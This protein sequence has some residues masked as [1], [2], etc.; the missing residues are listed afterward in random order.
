[1]HRKPPLLKLH[2]FSPGSNCSNTS[3]QIPER[4]PSVREV[5]VNLALFD[6]DGTISK[7]DS[8]LYFLWTVNRVKMMGICVA[9]V[10][11]IISYLA[12]RDSG[13]ALKERLLTKMFAGNELATLDE[14]AEDYCL[15]LLPDIIRDG[16]WPCLQRHKRDGDAIYIVS[17][18]PRFMLEPWCRHHHLKL[19]GTELEIDSNGRV[20]G[21]LSGNNCKGVEKVDRIV[22]EINLG[23]FEKIYAYGDTTSDLPMLELAESDK[24]FYQ[25]FR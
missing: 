17:A 6:F 19:I 24:R 18:S 13:T 5:Q 20:T 23:E 15:R 12:K 25:P 3:G 9:S 7:R 16:F 4:I 14:Q 1:M 2:T 21:R 11:G 10:P 22:A 8:F